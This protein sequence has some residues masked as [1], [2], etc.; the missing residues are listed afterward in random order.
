MSGPGIGE[1]NLSTNFAFFLLLAARIHIVPRRS[2]VVP[3]SIVPDRISEL[4]VWSV[5]DVLC[6]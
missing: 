6:R 4:S 5:V 1:S 2:I 3:G